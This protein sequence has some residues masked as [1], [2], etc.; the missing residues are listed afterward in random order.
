MYKEIVGWSHCKNGISYPKE[1]TRKL[2]WRKKPVGRPQK[3]WEDAIQ[4]DAA[5]RF[6]ILSWKAAAGDEEWRKNT[7]EAMAQK[8]AKAP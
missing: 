5:N 8:R 6:R 3:R 4:R 2:F 7:G 1:G